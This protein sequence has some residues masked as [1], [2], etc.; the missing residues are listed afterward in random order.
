MPVV[1]RVDLYRS[2]PCCPIRDSSRFLPLLLIVLVVVLILVVV[3]L[4]L[5]VLVVV[6]PGPPKFKIGRAHV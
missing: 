3:L 5:V 4:L 1:A 2:S 6:S